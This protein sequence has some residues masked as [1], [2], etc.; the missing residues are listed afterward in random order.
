MENPFDE[1]RAA[2]DR[3]REVKRAVESQSHAMACLLVGNLRHC[4]PGVLST[5]KKEL[6]DFNIHT[7]TWKGD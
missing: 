3:A 1:M 5:L 2:V 7:G 6:R 4:Y